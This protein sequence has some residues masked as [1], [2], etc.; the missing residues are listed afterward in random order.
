[1]TIEVAVR[2]KGCVFSA[3][4]AWAEG[5]VVFDEVGMAK[6]GVGGEG[7]GEQCRRG[8]L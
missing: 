7:S 5:P 8:Q 2:A 4:A 3:G 6:D 1:V